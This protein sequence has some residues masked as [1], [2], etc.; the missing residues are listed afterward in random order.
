MT[1]AHPNHVPRRMIPLGRDEALALL[2]AV[3][4]G[5]IV[6]TRHALPAVRPVSH[7][8][9]NGTIVLRTHP[10]AALAALARRLPMHEVVVAYEADAIDTTAHLG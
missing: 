2:G 6:F 9:D 3:C 1:G 5:R 7:L 10:D 4:L 8:L